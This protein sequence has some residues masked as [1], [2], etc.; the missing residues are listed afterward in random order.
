MEET[1]SALTRAVEGTPAVAIAAAF[2]WGVLSILLSPCHLAS[3][4]LVVGFIHGQGRM[5][6]QRAS[7][8]ATM[9]A[10]GILLALAGGWMGE[11]LQGRLPYGCDDGRLGGQAEAAQ[12]L[13]DGRVRGKPRPLACGRC[14]AGGRRRCCRPRTCSTLARRRP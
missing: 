7:L 6:T 9:F 3:I 5:S 1:F 11:A 12:D 13:L 8:I 2:I 4:P 10:V 14:R